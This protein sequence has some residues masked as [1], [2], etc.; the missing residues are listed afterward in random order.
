MTRRMVPLDFEPKPESWARCAL[1]GLAQR[2]RDMDQ[3][4]H[5]RWVCSEDVAKPLCNRLRSEAGA[6]RVDPPASHTAQ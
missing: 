5:G 4:G 2:L 6:S 3:V 1:C